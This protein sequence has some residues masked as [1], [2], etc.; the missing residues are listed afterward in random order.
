MDIYYLKTFIAIAENGTFGAAGRVVG[1]TQSAVSQQIKTIEEQLGVDLFD[2]AVRPPALT[3]H[4]LTFL[5]GAR[6]IVKEFEATT[7]ATKGEKLSG[8]LILG[9][10]R[11][12]FTGAL[13]KA[14][15]DLRKWYPPY[16]DSCT[17]P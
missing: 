16:S 6:R 12:S 2:R 11:T 17:H 7:R 15:S 9:A 5:E 3:V 10:I 4:G 8:N 13:P 14:L 1:L